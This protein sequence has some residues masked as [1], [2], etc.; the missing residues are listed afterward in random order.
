MSMY[1]VGQP[2]FE[3]EY[4]IYFKRKAPSARLSLQFGIEPPWSTPLLTGE[5][6]SAA[7]LRRVDGLQKS[8]RTPLLTEIWKNHR[9]FSIPN[10]SDCDQNHKK[11]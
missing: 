11:S 7:I 8:G 9:G 3:I 1:P 4:A 10:W 6:S 2:F 5:L